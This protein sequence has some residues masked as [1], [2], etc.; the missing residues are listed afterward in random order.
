VR[1]MSPVQLLA[2]DDPLND[3]F[4]RMLDQFDGLARNTP[5]EWVG[6]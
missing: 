3:W 6:V 4:N 5:K 1:I 2:D